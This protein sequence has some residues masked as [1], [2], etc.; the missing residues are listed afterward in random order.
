MMGQLDEWLFRS[1]AGIQ[2]DPERPGMQHIVI[3]PSVVGDIK[4]VRGAT[5][6]LYGT[7]EVEWTRDDDGDFKIDVILPTNCSADLF[8]PGQESPMAVRSGRNTFTSKL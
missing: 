5:T 4:H 8:M 2:I 3:R 1:L 7:V 6:T